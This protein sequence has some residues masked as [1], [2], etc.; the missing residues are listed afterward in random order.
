VGTDLI[1]RFPLHPPGQVICLVIHSFMNTQGR[2][3]RRNLSRLGNDA[4]CLAKLDN[5][6]TPTDG[7][8]VARKSK[9]GN[10]GGDSGG[11]GGDGRAFVKNH[12]LTAK[13][14][15]GAS[16]GMTSQTSVA[17]NALNS[18]GCR[19]DHSLIRRK[20][21]VPS[22]SSKRLLGRF[23]QT[24][25]RP[26]RQTDTRTRDFLDEAFSRQNDNG[27]RRGS[28]GVREDAS[29]N[30]NHR[31]A[32][33]T[34][35]RKKRRIAT[36]WN[37]GDSVDEGKQR[38]EKQN[39]SGTPGTPAGSPPMGSI[40][41]LNQVIEG[42]KSPQVS[43]CHVL[44]D[45]LSFGTQDEHEV[46]NHNN[47]T[48]TKGRIEVRKT[49]KKNSR[50]IQLH[51]SDMEDSN[52]EG[53][54]ISQ[55]IIQKLGRDHRD[56]RNQP[57]LSFSKVNNIKPPINSQ[58]PGERD[59]IESVSSRDSP[60]KKLR[61]DRVKN[62]HR[63]ED[64]ED[65]DHIGLQESQKRKKSPRTSPTDEVPKT[66][67]LKKLTN[68]CKK[69]VSKLT[70]ATH[71]FSSPETPLRRSQRS[72]RTAFSGSPRK[73]GPHQNDVIEL[74][75]DEESI[76]LS[77]MEQL[78]DDTNTNMASDV[79]IDGRE[80]PDSVGCDEKIIKSVH[81]DASTPR[82]SSRFSN[83]QIGQRVHCHASR[84]G[85]GSKVFDKK[86]AL[87]FQPSSRRQFLRIEY[88][89]ASSSEMIRHDTYLDDEEIKELYFYVPGGV[90]N[91]TDH[92]EKIK[93][94]GDANVTDS[95]HDFVVDLRHDE[96]MAKV[97][98]QV[99]SHSAPLLGTSADDNRKTNDSGDANAT[100][101]PHDFVDDL[102]YDEGMTQELEL[103]GNHSVPLLGTSANDNKKTC[104]S[105][106]ANAA[107]TSHDSVT[108]LRYGEGITQELEQ[109]ESHSA[110]LLGSS[111]DEK[112]S[113]KETGET[114]TPKSSPHEKS[115]Q[116]C[117]LI[118]RISPTQ[119]N[120]FSIYS[121]KYL[122]DKKYPSVKVASKK[123]LKKRYIVAEVH[124]K[125]AFLN[126]L[127]YLKKNEMLHSL[128][129]GGEITHAEVHDK[130]ISLHPPK[131][132]NE[133][134][135]PD[136]IYE[137]DQ[138]VLVFPFHVKSTELTGASENL[139]EADG[140]LTLSGG[141]S[142]FAMEAEDNAQP[143]HTQNQ[144]LAKVHTVT[145]RG[146]DYDRLKPY[147]FLNDTLI[148]F[149]I[150]WIIKR[151]GAAA[152][153]VHVFTTQF[154]T[155]LEDQGVD[156]VSSWTA[157]KNLDIF[158]KKFILIPVNKDIHWSLFVVVNP[159]KVENGYDLTI[160]N[161]DEVLEHSFCLF[162]DSL[163]AHK[164]LRMK[165]IIQ[166][167]LNAE[168][169]RLGKFKRLGKIEPF[170]SQSFPVVDPRGK[171]SFDVN[172]Q[173]IKFEANS[174]CTFSVLLYVS[175]LYCFIINI[176]PYQD[177]SWDCGVFVCRYAFGILRLINFPF[178][179]KHCEWTDVQ[180]RRNLLTK[181]ITE[182]PEFHFNMDDIA[183]LRIEMAHL[184][185]NLSIVYASKILL[186]NRQKKASE[187]RKDGANEKFEGTSAGS[188]EV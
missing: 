22:S 25:T 114:D 36:T 53:E 183:R 65:G 103:V 90:K 84:I 107:E 161:D 35:Q 127:D 178:A 130:I 100:D 105:R 175:F 56:M 118:M 115:S 129:M 39:L 137:P 166:N 54:A 72:R 136:A 8:K 89:N 3:A 173:D 125:L 167:W 141:S 98:E 185:T 119:E 12:K 143:E 48:M 186:K 162:M 132:E 55:K 83:Q 2:R 19:Q 182:S 87:Q 165:L 28:N 133:L 15:P 24:E 101:S 131:M 58:S 77:D 63:L 147:E 139:I 71:A 179:H 49:P 66:S 52:D 17:D 14:Q 64:F 145:I 46:K 57:G 146:E 40:F 111:T 164:K 76:A 188:M 75:S 7:K 91:S 92:N 32:S 86:C 121:N 153:N 5:V 134:E 51:E 122:T 110:S 27:Y 21:D 94:S 44:D 4:G 138:T 30:N 38:F 18:S 184:I 45:D 123:E 170:N 70:L 168:A 26:L 120:R 37:E 160:E 174:Q 158:E 124:D 144:R 159:G 180:R 10:A 68:F 169:R 82:R 126:L 181:W 102:R 112:S 9:A 88:E 157:K 13:I 151:M 60:Y 176:V 104:D 96:G 81:E 163:R 50:I 97:L 148:D 59:D 67:T 11:G 177:N 43:C 80:K 74:S 142:F 150:S 29:I 171:V 154:F 113:V 61:F 152:N 187:K 155:K 69:T 34:S 128:L 95:P 156:A 78:V 79:E 41:D 62:P 108:D 116:P 47:S 140:K 23:R 16:L 73:K 172:A 135:M 93:N 42:Y 99:E 117:Y 149:W 33:T 106:D 6:Q 31:I 20:V 85:V 1:T 109:V